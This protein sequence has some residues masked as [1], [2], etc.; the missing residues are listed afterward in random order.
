M[1]IWDQVKHE[2][3]YWS[4][5]LQM[6]VLGSLSSL[7]QFFS[8]VKSGDYTKTIVPKTPKSSDFQLVSP[9]P[10]ENRPVNQ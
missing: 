10:C 1:K 9:L 3:E 7:V 6:L 4:G 5:I 2:K 8:S